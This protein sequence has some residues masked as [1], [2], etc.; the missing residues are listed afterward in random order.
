MKT[1]HIRNHV[2][3]TTLTILGSMIG[4]VFLSTH[5]AAQEL[6]FS[7]DFEQFE[8]RLS[9]GDDILVIEGD[10]AYGGDD[11]KLHGIFE[12]EYSFE[13]NEFEGVE[14][15]ARFSKPIAPFWDAYG[16]IRHD[17]RPKPSQFFGVVGINGLA[18]YFIETDAS[19]FVSEDGD[20]FGRFEIEKDVLVTQRLVLQ[21][22]VELYLSAED[23]LD[24]S[25]L[26]LRLR[27]EVT[28]DIA[29]YFGVNQE[30]KW[31]Q[32]KRLAEQA[33]KDSEHLSFVLGI[34]LS[35]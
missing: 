20:V 13:G 28:R 6:F 29:P 14:L 8:T 15:Q 12:G 18:S 25:E 21:P 34:K 1:L 16:G 23:G 30:Q 5:V 33:G 17:I 26:G 3:A 7:A 19:L 31:G 24:S 10:I 9:D 27:Y 22:L 2:T 32:A 35:Y 4:S 11:W